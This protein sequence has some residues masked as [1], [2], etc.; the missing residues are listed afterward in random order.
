MFGMSFIKNRELQDLREVLTNYERTLEDIGWINLTQD[1]TSLPL[2]G[3]SFKKML[4]RVKL[5]YTRNPLAGQW[6]H[7]T[8][9]FVFG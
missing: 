3:E 5:Y 4:K 6:V 7:L 1:Q 8:T 9:A 2:I